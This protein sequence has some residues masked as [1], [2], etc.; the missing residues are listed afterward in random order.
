MGD[1]VT[2][3]QLSRL[4]DIISVLPIAKHFAD[5]GKMVRWLVHQN[6]AEALDGVSY[7]EPIIFKGS[8]HGVA[9]AAA[10]AKMLGPGE[11]IVTQIYGNKTAINHDM[12]SF[13]AQQWDR[14]G[15]VDKFHELPLVFDNRDLEAE[16]ALVAKHIPP[17]DKP[18]LLYKFDSHSSPFQH[19]TALANWLKANLS[20][21]YCLVNLDLFRA[22]RPHHLLGILDRA[23]ILFTV[24]TSI[25]HFA[26][27]TGTP[28]IVLVPDSEWNA[29]E[30]RFHW[31]GKFTHRESITPGAQEKMAEILNSD[32]PKSLRGS[33]V[34]TFDQMLARRIIHIVEDFAGALAHDKPRYAAAK[35]TWNVVAAKDKHWM[36]IAF[37]PMRSSKTELK[38]TRAMPF[39]R[40]MIDYAM[41][42]AS[43]KDYIVLANND[44][45]FVPEAAAIIR[46]KLAQVPCTYALRINM[47]SCP[48]GI[49]LKTIEHMKEFSGVD[50]F[51]FTPAWWKSQ[52]DN[53]PDMLLGCQ[54]WDFV[55]HWLMDKCTTQKKISP[56]I[57]YHQKH[58]SFWYLPANVKT[59][60]GQVH[61]RSLA[62]E[63][64][65]DKGIT[66]IL[67]N[68]LWIDSDPI[69]P[70]KQEVPKR[71]APPMAH[72]PAGQILPRPMNPEPKPLARPSFIWMASFPR[73]GNTFL[74]HVLDSMFGIK[75]R[76]IYK[77]SYP[78]GDLGEFPVN[79][80]STGINIV[81]THEAEHASM[82]NP[83][84]FLYRDGRAS[85]VSFAHHKILQGKLDRT[86]P[87]VLNELIE[88]RDWSNFVTAWWSNANVKVRVTYES[89]IVR[90]E[91]EARRISGALGLHV[92]PMKQRAI[93]SFQQLHAIHP[94]GYRKGKP[95]GWS[96]E[97][98][99]RQ[100]ERFWEINGKA[101]NLLGYTR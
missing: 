94:Q 88:S 34:R 28:S 49:H 30:P 18:I 17:T 73:S 37:R 60:P 78:E 13:Q 54:C 90:P 97:M 75:S 42:K 15:M 50:L 40:D 55:M 7:V 35:N 6:F 43:E 52:R 71:T 24:D 4:G 72:T 69:P 11:I 48:P 91:F 57:I 83:A 101:M 87:D 2:I 33:L 77:E 8:V 10:Q 68:P 59:N 81:K 36:T 31:I 89:L 53:F 26:Y 16:A 25:H 3:V 70:P 85:L 66:D 67:T 14:A 95:R 62:V 100:H 23:S 58:S 44:I 79:D 38:D 63:W 80:P 20:E 64:A 84:I 86:F 61:N 12:E 98:N 92:P 9:D 96:E 93:M 1:S 74:R 65:K 56:P 82:P 46:A 99:V 45:C 47:N 41:E 76:S 21:K 39:I 51:A 29:A 32:D 5:A 22:I 27:A 19:G